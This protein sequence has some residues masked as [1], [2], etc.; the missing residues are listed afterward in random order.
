M[1]GEGGGN[2]EF[3]GDSDE[4]TGGYGQ[5]DE[6]DIGEPVPVLGE[7]E[8]AGDGLEFGHA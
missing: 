3:G 4:H 2:V 1:E 7:D 8:H 6:V 5:A